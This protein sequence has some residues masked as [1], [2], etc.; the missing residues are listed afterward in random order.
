VLDG[1]LAVSVKSA[2]L[3]GA[4]SIVETTLDHQALKSD[5]SVMDQVLRALERNGEHR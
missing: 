3:E 2:C 4:G 5:E 1:D